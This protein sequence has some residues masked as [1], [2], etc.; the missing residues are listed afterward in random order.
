MHRPSCRTTSERQSSPTL[1]Q[2]LELLNGGIAQRSA[3]A[4]AAKY[5][6][7]SD[8]ALIE[9][10]YLSALSRKPAAVEVTKARG[11]LTGKSNRQ[12]AVAD[13]VWTVVNTQEFLFQH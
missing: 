4:G 5:A 8:D 13:L 12:E 9:E 1:L 2:A 11:F 6:A 10:L 7:M 3:T